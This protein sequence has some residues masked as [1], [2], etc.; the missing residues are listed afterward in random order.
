MI[1][2]FMRMVFVVVAAVAACQH[3]PTHKHFFLLFF[4]DLF[5]FFFLFFVLVFAT[6]FS[7]FSGR[8]Q[9]SSF[10]FHFIPYNSFWCVPLF[11]LL[12]Y[13]NLNNSAH[14]M[15][16]SRNIYDAYMLYGLCSCAIHTN[17]IVK[18]TSIIKYITLLHIGTY[19]KSYIWR[20]NPKPSGEAICRQL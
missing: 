8:L 9:F 14:D 12:L 4:F 20:I 18:H 1:I 7:V 16:D 2:H 3:I 6:A 17:G 11:L 5:R 13:I 10:F 15:P 19:Q